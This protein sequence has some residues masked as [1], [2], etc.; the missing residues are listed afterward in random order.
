M[1]LLIVL[2]PL[3]VFLPLHASLLA[4]RLANAPVLGPAEF[5]PLGLFLGVLL[6]VYLTLRLARYGGSPAVPSILLTLLGIGIALQFRIGTLQTV[7]ETASP[8]RFAIPLGVL[9]MLGAYLALRH[10]RINRLE[11][12]WG[13]FLG[14]AL[15][16]ILGVVVLG[17][18]FRGAKFLAGGMNPVEIVKPLLVVAIASILAGHRLLLRRGFA[19]IP[20]P[21][22]NI[23]VTVGIVWL[24]PMALLIVQGDFGMFALLNLTLLVMLSAVTNRAFY[25]LGGLAAVFF[26][27]RL[28]IPLT[29]RGQARLSAWL[30]P[31]A[32]AT[33]TGWQPLQAL[34]ALYSGGLFGT[35]F[36]AGSP[37]AVPIVDSDFAFVIVGEELGFVGCLFLMALYIGLVVSGM[38]V[39]S[40]AHSAYSACI[41]TGLTACLGIQTLLN[42]GGVVKAIPLTGIPL[43]LL[44][45]GGSSLVTTLLIGG[46]L[47]AIS[48]EHPS[49]KRK[50]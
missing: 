24:P 30:D 3:L 39:A 47:L 43:P 10:G 7:I 32:E 14:L 28:L 16:V 37:N 45:H 26:A 44:S 29:S 48:D 6:A 2:L 21:P 8:S 40:R 12:Y 35:G 46:I 17:H 13:V 27:A 18:G 49:L 9:V 1:F 4:V 11:P 5:A 23:L 22:L 31:F 38:R 36:G 33:S 42:V 50:K 41:A 20:L 25:L 15:C 19:G 34:V